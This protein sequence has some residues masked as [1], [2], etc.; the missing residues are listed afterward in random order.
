M[1]IIDNNDTEHFNSP[2]YIL[3]EWRELRNQASRQILVPRPIK[4]ADHE[5]PLLQMYF[6]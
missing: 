5:N 3:T 2:W 4:P 1:L 6:G